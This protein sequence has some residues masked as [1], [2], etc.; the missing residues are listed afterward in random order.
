[1]CGLNNFFFFVNQYLFVYLQ[2]QS[3]SYSPNHTNLK[4]SVEH[5]VASSYAPPTV[6][7]STTKTSKTIPI[8]KN[9]LDVN[10]PITIDIDFLDEENQ[11]EKAVGE[12]FS[13][14][15]S[16]FSTPKQDDHKITKTIEPQLTLTGR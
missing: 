3:H 16:L 13:F 2:Q 5:A 7:E 15:S 14:V 11:V 10:S 4:M 6:T 1:M 12:V 8:P 9:V